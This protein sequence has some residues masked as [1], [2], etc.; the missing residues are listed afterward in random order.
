[1]SHIVPSSDNP[2]IQTVNA[3]LIQRNEKTEEL[4]E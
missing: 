3:D 4:D 2:E 1:M